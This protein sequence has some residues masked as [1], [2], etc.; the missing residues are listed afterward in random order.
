M[1]GF[2]TKQTSFQIPALPFSYQ[3]VS[4]LTS[5]SLWTSKIANSALQVV[6]GAWHS[7]CLLQ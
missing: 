4:F 6:S 3:V 5:M 2:G 7:P 1:V